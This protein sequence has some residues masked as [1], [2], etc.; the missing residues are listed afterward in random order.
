ML[1]GGVDELSEALFRGFSSLRL[2]AADRGEGEA[3]RPYDLRR[4]GIILGEGC[5]ILAIETEEHAR[6]RGAE[7]Y[8]TILDGNLIGQ[9]RKENGTE[10]LIRSVRSVWRGKENRSPD[11]LSGAGNSSKSLDALEAAGMKAMFPD[12]YGQIP[13]SSIKSMTGEAIASGGIRLV[14]DVLS[15]VNQFIPPTVNYTT[16]DPDCDLSYVTG[17]SSSRRIE[18]L[19]HLGISPGR[20]VSSI[21]IGAPWIS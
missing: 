15:L 5:G 21:L 10:G 2:L 4:N 8:G 19:L 14:A 16:P 13:V 18:T 20:C 9:S 6:R 11:Y 7:I 17:R 12:R 1:T 3:C